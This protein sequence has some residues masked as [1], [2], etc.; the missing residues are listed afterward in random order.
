VRKLNNLPIRTKLFAGFGLVCALFVIAG[1]SIINFNNATVEEVTS[2]ETEVLPHT[3]NYMEI[4]RDIEQIQGW[5]TD[6]S[7][8]RGAKGYDD[9]FAEAE[10]YYKDAVNRIDHAI[11]AHEK[12]GEADMV[13]LLNNMR[14]SL[15]DYYDM[16]KKMA[17]AYID[18]G[19]TQGNLWMEKF[20]PFAAKIT[21]IIDKVV[22]EHLAELHNSFKS[23]QKQS[24]LT[25]KFLLI[26]IIV[27]LVLSIF[28]AFLIG[29]PINYS[30][31]KA[32]DFANKIAEGDFR[33]TLD[34]DQKDEIGMLAEALNSMS[35]NL[36][37]MFGE[38]ATGVETLSASSTE[39]ATISDQ[40]TA[41]SDQTSEKTNNVA[42][43]AEEMATTMN[44]V[45]TASEQTT[46]NIQM[47]A[48][49]T[50]EMTTTI[51][52]I[53]F[54]TSKGTDVTSQA[55]Q[56]ATD[57]SEKIGELGEATKEIS[58]I[59]ETITEISEQTNLLALNATIEAARAG[60]AGK[61]FAVVAGEIKA[62][63]Q[64]TAEATLEIKSL[65]ARVQT[66]T[67]DS[68]KSISSIASVINEINAIVGTVATAIEEQS[69]TTK[70][71]SNNISQAAVGVQE[72]NYNVNETSKV[73][74]EVTKDITDASIA[75][76]EIST[77]SQQVNTSASE[78]S[79]LAEDI[80]EMVTHFR[81]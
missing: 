53:A 12:Y 35:V 54:N 73:S 24:K 44:S 76:N 62:L 27:V 66:I 79:K 41:S 38:I 60:E 3:L 67:S 14:K 33:Q 43:A 19:P 61:G 70:E 29:N 32:V 77:G 37:S 20:D 63:S 81:I 26:A 21:S 57:A 28:I 13:T 40:I 9:G 39:L 10:N 46:T 50:E 18:D 11:I 71:I 4:K 8:T 45:A 30:L 7:A 75:T 78:L 5:L 25:S 56:S 15:D 36:R 72:M 51:N 16:G 64:Q 74:E 47:I 31:S 42:A 49:A 55:V 59:T 2:T 1:L 52:E 48:T 34:I 80:N 17:Q 69:V 58:K 65:I 68:V 6:I 23:I 22:K